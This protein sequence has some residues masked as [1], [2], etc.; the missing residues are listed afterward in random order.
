MFP[1]VLAP[2][3]KLKHVDLGGTAIK[4]LPL[5]MQ[6]LEGLQKLSLG[7]CNMLEINEPSN[8]FQRLPM[9]FPNLT[10]LL[11]RDLDITILPASIE[12]CHSLELLHVTN[13][14]KLE[15]I[16]GFPLS[17]KEFSVANSPVK[18]NSLTF[19]LR[20]VG[21]S[22]LLECLLSSFVFFFQTHNAND[23]FHRPFILLQ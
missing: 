23:S 18:A 15:E 17:I 5:S 4:N 10:S 16:R 12:E 19:K 11:L 2:M 9:L 6:N 1:E 21:V 14:K 13:C 8:F 7:K 3:R 20:Q 22:I